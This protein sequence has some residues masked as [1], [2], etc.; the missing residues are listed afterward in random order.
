MGAQSERKGM[1]CQII[2]HK[3]IISNKGQLNLVIN[4]S[5]NGRLVDSAGQV[6]STNKIGF[7]LFSIASLGCQ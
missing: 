3:S 2:N 1:R 7:E 5:T 6:L 4:K